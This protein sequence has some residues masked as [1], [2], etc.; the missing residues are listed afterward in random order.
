MKAL[1]QRE[2]NICL[3]ISTTTRSPRNGEINGVDYFFVKK[4][5]FEKI[6]KS[7]GFLE[8]AE[9]FGN[10]YGT[11]IGP[12]NNLLE[13]GKDLIFDVDWQGGQQIRESVL[14]ESC[15]AHDSTRR[16]RA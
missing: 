2:E 12:V 13:E 11:P 4:A 8:W 15:V 9:V 14:K 1:T 7:G 6:K 3:S 10:L 5:E 16:V